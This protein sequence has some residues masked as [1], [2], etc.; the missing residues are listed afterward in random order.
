M[1]DHTKKII[2]VHIPKNAGESIEKFFGG[3]RKRERLWGT[4]EDGT[5][6]QHLTAAEIKHRFS[7]EIF[8]NYFKFTF[9]RNPF[10]RCVS[11][12]FW[13]KT[14]LR[15]TM[16]FKSWVKLKL[17]YLIE[18]SRSKSI[19]VIRRM[20]NLPQYNFIYG[21]NGKLLVDFVGKFENLQ[22]DFNIVCDKIGIPRQQ[23][24]HKNKT[25]HKHYTEYYDNETREIVEEKYARDIEYFGYKF[26]E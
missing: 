23:L 16:D 26:G 5:I 19:H 14:Q 11:E 21:N 1:I 2:F 15:E 6:L 24:P 25:K 12:Y 7:S 9:V 8:D 17:G 18:N 4:E 3:Y 10:S 20:H 22:Q 13:E